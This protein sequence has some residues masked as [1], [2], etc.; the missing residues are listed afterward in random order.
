M[1]DNREAR[2][3]RIQYFAEIGPKLPNID[4]AIE[5]GVIMLDDD[6]VIFTCKCKDIEGLPSGEGFSVN[7]M[8][9]LS[10]A[11]NAASA[12]GSSKPGAINLSLLHNTSK[13]TLR[14][15]VTVA[16]AHMHLTARE[17]Y[18]EKIMATAVS[19]FGKVQTEASAM[20]GNSTYKYSTNSHFYCKDYNIPIKSQSFRNCI[21][22]RESN[23]NYSLTSSMSRA[24]ILDCSYALAILGKCINCQPCCVD[25]VRANENCRTRRCCVNWLVYLFN[26]SQTGIGTES[27]LTFDAKE[28]FVLGRDNEPVRKKFQTPDFP[29]SIEYEEMPWLTCPWY[30]CCYAG[31][32]YRNIPPSKKQSIE[33][34]ETDFKFKRSDSV[35]VQFDYVP[36]MSGDKGFK[37]LRMVVET[38]DDNIDS[39]HASMRKLVSDIGF[40]QSATIREYLEGVTKRQQ[41]EDDTEKMAK[42]RYLAAEKRAEKGVFNSSGYSSFSFG[43]TLKDLKA[44]YMG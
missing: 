17:R 29:V 41:E 23:V 33:R 26:Y 18:L 8:R 1:R 32:Q 39:I 2:V 36:L 24:G 9:M 19:M 14:F 31:A 38:N 11:K 12:P 22:Y 34:M 37:K 16:N 4:Q 6:V 43:E 27:K 7:P 44:K 3:Q 25:E 28:D 13:N 20:I 42:F 10:S 35:V 5:S 30:A 40:T 15:H 21:V